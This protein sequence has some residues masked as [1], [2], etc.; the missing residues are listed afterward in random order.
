MKKLASQL[1]PAFRSTHPVSRLIPAFRSTHPVSRFI[2]PAF[3]STLP[4]LLL[5]ILILL[6]TFPAHAQHPLPKL[7]K[8][9]L[10][11]VIAA[12]TLEEKGKLVVGM[13]LKIPGMPANIPGMPPPDPEADALPEKVPGAAGRTHPI[14]RLGIPSITVTDGPAG[15]RIEPIR[16]NDSTRTYYATAWP[17]A[18]LLASSWDTALV[19]KVGTAFGREVLEYGSDILLGPAMNIHR[20]PLGGRNF[21]YYSEDPLIAG[22]MAAAMVKGIQSNGVGTSIKHFAANNQETDRMTVNTLASERALREIYLKGFE[23]AIRQSDPYTVMSSY[24]L[25]NGTYTSQQPDLLTTILRKEW[26]FKGLVMSDW[27]AGDDPVAQMKAGNDLIMPGNPDQSKKIVEAVKNGSL[28]IKDLNRNVEKILRVILRSP[29]FRKYKY[30]DRPDLAADALVSRQ[31]A[32]GSMVLLKNEN[33]TLPLKNIKKIALFGN[34][35][36]DLVAGGTGSG[37]VN[38]PYTISLSQGLA[39]ANYQLESDLQTGYTEYIAAA[40]AAQPKDPMAILN[41]PPPPAEMDLGTDRIDR[42]AHEDDLAIVTIGRNAGE[43]KDRKEEGDYYLS[44]KEKEMLKTISGAFHAQGKKLV[45]VLNIGGV[46]DMVGWQDLADAIL[47]AWQPGMEGGNA[48]TAIL[49]GKIN[50]SG[51]LACT[52]PLAYKDVPSAGNFPGKEFKEKEQKGFFGMPMIPAEVEYEEGIYVGY[53]YYTSFGIRTAYPFGY[54]LSYTTFSYSRL[55]VA[56]PSAAGRT[57][58]R[59]TITNT[60]AVAGK[61]AVQIY[62]S[63]PA[64][65]LDKPAEE[66]KAFA[67]TRLLGPGESQTL[68]FV[69]N[70]ASLASFD[71][72]SASWIAEAGDYTVKAGASCEDIRQTQHFRLAQS[73][74]AEKDHAVLAPPHPITS[75]PRSRP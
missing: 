4:I 60:G 52:F 63:A 6:S 21:E 27:F 22:S 28:D 43:G 40:K 65:Q 67:K 68:H 31:A 39:A 71:P 46:I 59:L 53:R 57:E 73:L 25:L 55:E 56:P 36:Y 19:R 34:N 32:A 72:H 74:I 7:G 2:H 75:P 49:G 45:V 26:G 64:G 38:R 42:T 50:P 15:I 69:L 47:L 11:A 29:E 54:G 9:P 17:V 1:I 18:T 10:P 23:I 70:A 41:P 30:T 14:A 5:N 51:K 3:R 48:I 24:N 8:D 16:G 62:L 61:E 20:N 33:H 37:D 44:A 66:L 12:M 58:I 35:S 13:G